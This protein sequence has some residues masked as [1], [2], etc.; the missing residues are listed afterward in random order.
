M[1]PLPPPE[2]PA[3]ESAWGHRDDLIAYARRILGPEAGI[4][5]DVVQ[6]AYLRLH[7]EA[8]AG[9]PAGAERPWLFRVVRNLALDERRRARSREGLH[10]A[11]AAAPAQERGPLE[12]MQLSEAARATLDEI[13][14]LPPVDR[15]VL[16]LDQAGLP[17]TTIAR[18]TETTPN[19]VH[20]S[21]FRA[22]R[23]LRAVS[24]AAW[25]LLPLP[26][27][28][29]LMRSADP[30]V[31]SRLPRGS[32]EGVA[33]GVAAAVV[34]VATLGGGGA[35]VVLQPSPPAVAHDRG[36][37][38]APA[39]AR[40]AAGSPAAAVA[41]PVVAVAT[42]S[43]AVAGARPATASSTPAGTRA[44]RRRVT[45]AS[46]PPDPS[47]GTRPRRSAPAAP[48]VPE[49][50]GARPWKPRETR[51][52]RRD[53]DDDRHEDD[54]ERGDDEHEDDDG[55]PVDQEPVAPPAAVEPEDPVADPQPAPEA[56][57]PEPVETAPEPAPEPPPPPELPAPDDD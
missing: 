4:A 50:G 57:E 52:G 35:L 42:P 3:A 46:T 21:L 36:G 55:E 48:A 47:A 32:G 40:A 9:R 27:V 11:L 37:A 54:W 49:S 26:L 19:A 34:A 44:P 24:S 7:E 1:A 14:Q 5:E 31:L 17:P 39:L 20:Q 43:P 16:L 33:G 8:A 38:S 13:E 28:R 6:E 56:P 10:E 15:R 23:R 2:P 29:A 51:D 45:P 30:A 41:L 18:L 22:R 12:R 53:R 25:A